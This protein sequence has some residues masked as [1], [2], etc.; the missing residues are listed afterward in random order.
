[1]SERLQLP[2]HVF[3][4]KPKYAT[5][6]GREII[7]KIKEFIEKTGEPHMWPGHSH[8]RPG[9]HDRIVYLDTFDLPQ[10]HRGEANRDRWAPCPCCHLHFPKY[11][12]AGMIAWFPDQKLIRIL[13]PQCF[14]KLNPEGHAIAIDQYDREQ[15]IRRDIA[16]LIQNLPLLPAAMAAIRRAIEI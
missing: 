8:S 10:S 7:R 14:R 15:R 9:R 3:T 5:R 11:F 6:P 12:R 4:D 1:M 2:A 16:F 13:G